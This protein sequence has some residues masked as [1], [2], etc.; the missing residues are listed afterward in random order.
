M[1]EKF[2]SDWD[3]VN[4][5]DGMAIDYL[6]KGLSPTETQ[7]MILN[8]ELFQEWISIERCFSVHYH[9]IARFEDLLSNME[10]DNYVSK[11]KSVALQTMHDKTIPNEIEWSKYN[12]GPTVIVHGSIEIFDRLFYQVGI[13][14]SPYNL[15]I[16]IGQLCKTMNFNQ[17]IGL[18]EFLAIFTNNASGFF[19]L[20]ME[21]LEKFMEEE[22][23]LEEFKSEFIVKYKREDFHP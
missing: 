2:D 16:E 12:N 6:K 3:L 18:V 21:K 22:T 11:L 4:K 7:I 23:L 10:F 9:D 8:S 5:I 17:P 13:N 1:Q 15:G 20:D 14:I 19:N